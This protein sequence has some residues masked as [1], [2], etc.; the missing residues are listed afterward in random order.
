MSNTFGYGQMS[1]DD[2]ATDYANIAFIVKRML[3]RVRTAMPVQVISCSNNGAVAAIGTV[4]V[5]PLVNMVD[6]Q[7]NSQ[8]HGQIF[9]VPYFRLQA[10][11][12]AAIIAD[13]VAGDIGLLCVSDRDI[14]AVQ[15]SQAAANPGSLRR[16][17]L[18]D[19]MYVGLIISKNVPTSYIQFDG[20]GNITIQCPQTMTLNTTQGPLNMTGAGGVN[21]TDAV[22]IT[23]TGDTNING[24]VAATGPT[25]NLNATSGA[26]GL[27]GAGGVNLTGITG[28]TGATTITGNTRINGN[29]TVTG[30]LSPGGPTYTRLIV[31]VNGTSGTYTPPVGFT[32]IKVRKCAGGG[33]GG[34]SISGVGGDGTDTSFGGWVAVHGKGGVAGAGGTSVGGSGGANGTG[35]LIDRIQGGGGQGGGSVASNQ[36]LGGMG[37]ANPFGGAGPGAGPNNVGGAAAPNTG[38]GGGGGGYQAGVDGRSGGGGAAGEY[39]EFMMTAAQV[40]ALGG[41]INWTL[42]QGG[43]AGSGSGISGGAGAN[44]KILIEE[45]YT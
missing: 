43:A 35:T 45:F 6:G 7:N 41:S 17:D 23:L 30:T 31:P 15:N 37:G 8:A 34:A 42:G 36:L 24:N 29:L 13:P 4:V 28:I 10:G 19:G 18:A 14:S 39:V 5:Q 38:A 32:R 21:I 12:G 33:G 40:A 3:A 9:N 27:T 26:L 11:S 2:T 16:F 1:P 22:S 20:N 25:I 44:G